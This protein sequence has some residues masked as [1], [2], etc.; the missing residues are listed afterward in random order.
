MGTICPSSTGKIS[1]KRHG[2]DLHVAQSKLLARDPPGEIV[3]QFFFANRESFDDS[4]LLPLERFAFKY[5]RNSPPQEVDPRL[6]IFAEN[7]CGAA[8]QRQQSRAVRNLEIVDVAAVQRGLCF[9][10]QLLNHLGDRAAAAGSGQAADKDVVTRRGEFDAHL[11]CTQ[12]A[13]LADKSFASWGL[14]RGFKRNARQIA[15]PAQLRRRQFL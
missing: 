3:H 14:C 1:G 2:S 7:I 5:L 4:A 9:R 8:R 15:A 13:F 6:H 11:Q 12:R 10:M